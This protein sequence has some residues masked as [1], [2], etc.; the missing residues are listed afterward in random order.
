MEEENKSRLGLQI[1]LLLLLC[2]LLAIG[3]GG[4]LIYAKQNRIE[5]GKIEQSLTAIAGLKAGQINQWIAVNVTNIE[6]RAV[7]SQIAH[8]AEK[9]FRQGTL[10]PSDAQRLQAR[11]EYI[12]QQS[13]FSEMTIVDTRGMPRMSTD[14]ELPDMSADQALIRQAIEQKKTVLGQMRHDTLPDGTPYVSLPVAAPLIPGDAGNAVIGVLWVELDASRFLFPLLQ[15]WPVPSETAEA[16]LVRRDGS[17]MLALNDYRTQ[18]DTALKLRTPVDHP[19]SVTAQAARGATGFIRGTDYRNASV[20]GYAVQ[21]PGT[22]WLMIAKIDADEAYG[23]FHRMALI[24]IAFALLLLAV[25]SASLFFWWRNRNAQWEKHKAKWEQRN[26]ASHTE[27]LQSELNQQ[28]VAR[29]YEY[30]SKYANDIIVLLDGAGKIVEVNDRA[31]AAYGL[32]RSQL[33]GK[34]MR[35]LRAPSVDMLFEQRWS[36]IQENKSLM[37]ECVHV[38]A[39][40][41]DFPV[42]VSARVIERGKERFVQCIVRDITE[43]KTAQERE[44]RL[45]DMYRALGMTNE[46]IIR[47]QA[48]ADLFPLV[49]RIA[50]ECGGMALAWVGVADG[51]NRLIPVSNYGKTAGYLEDLVVMTTPDAPEG[52]GVV[53]IAFRENRPAITNDINREESALPWSEKNLKYGIQ[54]IAAFPILRSAKPYAVLVVYS[55]HVNAFDREIVHLLE[56]MAANI[57]FALDN[58]DRQTMQQMSKAALLESATRLRRFYESKIMGV[59]YWNLNGEITTANDK[60]LELAGYARDDLAAGK[61]NWLDMT[62]PEQRDNERNF[63]TEIAAKGLDSPPMEKEYLRKDGTR[64]PVLI[65]AMKLDAASGA[66]FLIDVTERKQAEEEL[67]LAAMVYRDSSEAMMVTDADNRIIAVNPAFEHITG[68]SADEVLGKDPNLLKSGRHDSEVYRDMWEALNATG[69]WKGELWNRGK[70]GEEF[71]VML[72]ISTTFDQAGAVL[73][74]VALFSDI[75]RKKESDELIWSQANFDALTGLPNRRLFRDHLRHEIR[76]SRR[77]NLPLALM[78]LD[79]DGFKDV[80]DTLGHDMGD[81]LLKDAAERLN[82][83]V[84]EI[85]TVARLGGDEF[86]VILSEL[87]DPGNVDRVARHILQ[88]LSE[89]FKLGDEVAHVSASIGITLFPDDATEIEELIKNA[90]QAMYAAKQHGRNQFQY[91]TPAMQEAAQVKMRLVND[92]RGA[93]ENNQFELVY[94]PIVDLATGIIIKAEALI[95]WQHPI[96][97]LIN[98]AEFIPAAE[99]TGMIKA[100]GNWVFHEAASQ[101]AQWREKYRPEFQISVNI[102]PVQFRNE[103]IDST[104]WLDHLKILGLPAQ[105]IVVEITEG[106]LLEATGKVTEQLLAFHE[107]GIEIALDDFGVGYSS[108]SYLKKFDIDYL[109]IDQSFVRN[110][111]FGSSDAAL[112]EAIIVMAHKLGLKVIA[113]G[114]ETLQQHDLLATAECDYVQG[115]LFSGPLSA[116]ELEKLLEANPF[117]AQETL[118]L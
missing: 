112:C 35:E 77:A 104:A 33:I 45:M 82:S 14:P 83:C 100:F 95:R 60:F 6:T 66:V 97:G 72:S 65:A 5:T 2:L 96:R 116:L 107:A 41:T 36:E 89:P 37:F 43:R 113:E 115:Y 88:K 40:G 55:D 52:R 93:L 67:K 74:R 102:S 51:G 13:S 54:S 8:R 86:T 78:F 31:E 80:N 15:S 20:L 24:R 29:Q 50:V 109:K 117:A 12:R 28:F 17:D 4:Y 98:P 34:S 23:T 114:V 87:H 44:R 101:A 69:R 53:G 11:L 105:G 81:V 75:T 71:A 64:I 73:R 111:A 62:P 108:L 18:K 91:F 10:P 38:R 63:L 9:W 61:I 32:L 39:D 84:R 118:M 99:D 30:L 103:G 110:L 49:C 42:E 47:L 19:T 3:G 70:N 16:I 94:Q 79:L 21:I 1:P 7:N 59:A 85:D 46:A 106:L 90:D 25:S 26:A 56:E 57:S 22:D 68:Y 76:K 27:Q 58:F 92:L 48:E